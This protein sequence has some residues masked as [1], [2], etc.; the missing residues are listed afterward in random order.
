MSPPLPVEPGDPISP[1]VSPLARRNLLLLGWLSL[2]TDLSSQMIFPLMP[3]FLT[4]TLGATP[5]VVG[6]IDGAA[7]SMAALLKLYSGRWSDRMQ[8]RKPWIAFG[9]GLSALSKLMFVPAASWLFVLGARLLERVGK[10]LRSAPRDAMIADSVPAEVR[11]RAFG[12][13]RGMDALGGVLGALVAWALIQVMPIRDVFILAVIPA[14]VGVTLS[15]WLREVPAPVSAQSDSATAEL[16]LAALPRKLKIALG[17]VLLGTTGR[18]GF[19]F[20]LLQAYAWTASLPITLLCYAGYQAVYALIASPIGRLSDRVGRLPVMQAGAL[21]FT[22]CFLLLPIGAT[23]SL[24]LSFV[25]YGLAEAALD[26]TQRA[27]IV[28]LA[29]KTER[30]RAL[31]AY[32]ATVAACALPA[33]A[34]L[35]LL[36]TTSVMLACQLA[37]GITLLQWVFLF[38]MGRKL[39]AKS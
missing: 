3:F 18:L 4:V 5:F 8:R 31:G 32:H 23:W 39:P 34:V 30:G 15:W 19:A 20:L 22:L 28:D 29:P 10:G 13:Q 21:L 27:W 35:G 37:A 25:C 9:Y 26:T 1:L 7:E 6:L 11:G 38:V 36:W 33:G 24:A 12:F 17:S 14:F 2:L 16:K